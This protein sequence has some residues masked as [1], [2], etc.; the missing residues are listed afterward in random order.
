MRK[1]NLLS[2]LLI[3]T[4]LPLITI[5]ILL[6]S[7]SYTI[8]VDELDSNIDEFRSALIKERKH[9]LKEIIEVA[10]GI[11][12]YQTSLPNQGDIKG[13]L[14]DLRFGGAGY[15]FIYDT[16]GTN[17]FH[18]LKPA[19]EGKNLIDLEDTKGNKIIVGLLDAAKNGGGSFSYFYQKPGSQEQ[20]EKM[21][22]SIMIPNTDWMIGTGAYLDDIEK[23][24]EDYALAA[25][26]GLQEKMLFILLIAS[27][28]IMVTIFLIF[29]MAARIVKPIQHMADN[30]NNIAQGEGDLTQ[31]LDILGKDETAQLGKSFNTF[32]DKLKNTIDEIRSATS[33]IIQSGSDINQ[34][35]ADISEELIQHNNE[36]EQVVTAITEMSYTANEVA[37]NSNQVAEA[38][39]AVTQDVMHAQEC[40]EVSLT[41]V[42]ELVKEVDGAAN[43]M[44]A[45]SE[46]SQKIN[47][48]LTVIGAIAEQT[49]LL[50][51]NAAIEAA[52]AGEQGRGFAVVAD[53]V[54]SLA[55]RTQASTLEINEML[56]ELHR[57]VTQ[58]VDAMSL[59]Q[60]RSGRTVESS[61]TISESLASVTT[62]ITSINDKSTQI[63]TATTEQSSVT[64]EINRNINAIQEI[65][66]TLTASSIEAKKAAGD[67]LDEG[68]RL[69]Q[70]VSQ[71]KT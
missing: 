64:E 45:L 17:I 53:E 47:N 38:I 57:L 25:E 7:I 18:G 11:I 37:N 21:G 6:I 68:D 2:K 34:Q 31:R 69:D 27:T 58:S 12:A 54:R 49:N 5:L 19:V 55:S 65:V 59:S 14:R 1:L 71:F 26:Q 39:Q 36:T 35:S 41:E 66:N 56:T 46:Q 29:I 24:I 63:A 13:A 3:L 23:V 51:L 52:R 22:Y 32:V 48:V 15:F 43:S 44:N 40:V 28:L 50:A 16:Q 30:L 42:S 4:L 20:S 70:L 60:K 9:Q 33:G 10:T 67:V 61:R 62:A 8:E